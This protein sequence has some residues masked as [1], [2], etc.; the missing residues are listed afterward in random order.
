MSAGTLLDRLHDVGIRLRDPHDGENR[1]RCPEC[2]KGPNDDALAVLIAA[3]R[4]CWTC[5]RCGWHGAASAIQAAQSPAPRL[6][7]LPQQTG[8]SEGYKLARRIWAEAVPLDGTV[9]ADYLSRRACLVPRAN[10]D[11]R[12]HPRLFCAKAGRLLP[13]IVCRVSTVIGNSGIGIHRIFLDPLGSDR[14]LAKM[15][16]GGAD[17]PVCIRLFPDDAVTHSLGLAEGVETALAAARLHSPIW[18]T[19]DAGGLRA[20]PVL[21]GIETLHIFAD[22]DRAGILAAAACCDRWRAAGRAVIAIAPPKKGAD[23]NDVIRKADH[24]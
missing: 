18:S 14:A 22:H 6:P 24:V 16:L 15:R 11:L 10:G 23:F 13:A 21:G 7:R 19:I 12:F 2:D 4:A 8:R 5:H 3:D 17:E 9:G 1:A 20:F